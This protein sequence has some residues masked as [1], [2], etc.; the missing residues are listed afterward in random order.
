[1]FST[2]FL[3]LKKNNMKID[4]T[5]LAR[6]AILIG[7]SYLF[8]EMLPIISKIVAVVLCVVFVLFLVKTLFSK[9]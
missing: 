8:F 2:H 5:I 1:M 3:K 7:I 4:L 9:K 6:I